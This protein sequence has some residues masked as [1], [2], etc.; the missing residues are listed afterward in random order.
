MNR[1]FASLLIFLLLIVVERRDALSQVRGWNPNSVEIYLH[2]VEVGD[3]IF[4]NF[5]HTALRL[6]DPKTG[7]DLIYNWGIFDFGDPVTFSL[8][9]YSGVLDYQLGIYRTS[10]SIMRY[11]REGRTV[12]EDRLLLTQEETIRLL[13]RLDWNSKREN[14]V[15]DY[16]YFFDN[17]S[18]KPRD[19]FEEALGG[20]LKESSEAIMTGKTF[21]DM[22]RSHYR[23]VPFVE[24][25]LEVFMNGRLEREMTLWQQ[26]FL[27]KTLRQVLLDYRR[28]DGSPIMK[29]SRTIV[30]FDP[31]VPYPVS[32]QV[33]W[34]TPLLVFLLFCISKLK[35]AHISK[36]FRICLGVSG[37]LYFFITGLIGVLLP[38]NWALSEHLDLHANWNSSVIWPIQFLW[39]VLFYGILFGKVKVIIAKRFFELYLK[40]YVSLGLIAFL[41]WFMGVIEQDISYVLAA[42]L[43]VTIGF[44]YVG[45]KAL[46]CQVNDEPELLL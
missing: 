14:R 25:G 32:G 45:L 17:C 2:T 38:L 8:K 37:C 11:K 10:S 30:E 34:S 43:P 33:L 29:P 3:L 13:E 27:P 35:T 22:V 1:F 46:N 36:R 39:I 9:F 26:M 6:Y 21:R 44:M 5:G 19:Y 41:L 24:V 28:P 15:Y 23:S 4:N 18:T 40:C 7:R 16:D 42:F 12:W 31:P 20:G